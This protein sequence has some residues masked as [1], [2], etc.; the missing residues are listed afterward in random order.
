[1]YTIP[2]QAL[3]QNQA[4]SG[5]RLKSRAYKQYENDLKTYL[6]TLDLPKL[7]PKQPYYLFLIFGIPKQQD[8][9]NGIKLFEDILSDF[10]G[11]NDRDVGSLYVR[12]E[13]TKKS[14]CFIKFNI[15]DNEYDLIR[16]ITEE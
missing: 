13:V 11:I 14:D 15:F 12:K 8:C 6:L 5:R 1:M 9:S 16:T 10:L 3:S 4:W 7:K 2:I